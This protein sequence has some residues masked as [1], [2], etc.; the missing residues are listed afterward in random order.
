MA[1]TNI[2]MRID[3][4]LKQDAEELFAD[5]G[6]SMT[7]A[8]TVFARQAVREQ[9]IPFHLSRNMPNARTVKAIED[10]QNGIGLSK[11][12]TSMQELVDD[13]NAND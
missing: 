5:L 3:S 6:L 2:T 1:S 8:F 12:F 10:A 7:S 11:G 13:L 9:R 4:K